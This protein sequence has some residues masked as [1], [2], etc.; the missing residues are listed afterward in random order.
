MEPFRGGGVVSGVRDDRTDDP[1]LEGLP[2]E[3]RPG[4]EADEELLRLPPPPQHRRILTGA[5]MIAVILAS[6]A[7]IA[8]LRADVRYFFAAQQATAL[9]AVTSLDPARVEPDTFVRV[10]GLPMR[11]DTVRFRRLVSSTTFEV[12]PLAG[13]RNVFVQ[14]PVGEDAPAP[15]RY[16]GRLLTFGAAG[17]RYTEVRR[18]L[19]RMGLPVTDESFLLLASET[20]HDYA[21]APLLAL[22]FAVFLGTNLTLLVRMFVPITRL[23]P[24]RER[25]RETS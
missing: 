18:E 23:R 25:A 21:W 3:E 15:G 6:A 2:P 22:L 20:P 4:D 16:E 14:V 24:V 19:L 11:A 10:H 13:Q 7:M 9:G 8:F 5:T 12:F 17:S 1:G